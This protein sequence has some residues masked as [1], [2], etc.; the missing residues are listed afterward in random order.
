MSDF[1]S[2]RVIPILADL[3]MGAAYAD[4]KIDGRELET[5]RAKLRAWLEVDTLPDDVKEHLEEFDPEAF[6][7]EGTAALLR[8]EDAAQSRKVLELVVAVHEADDELDLDEDAYLRDLAKAMGLDESNYSD[9]KLEILSVEDLRDGIRE[10]TAQ[11]PPI[12]KP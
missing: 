5:V 8:F 4:R 6:N 1:E 3:L 11:P 12:P 7:L 10:I 2:S 9:L